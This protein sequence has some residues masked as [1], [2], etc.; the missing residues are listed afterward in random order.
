[1]KSLNQQKQFKDTTIE[2]HKRAEVVQTISKYL[3]EVLARME[4][5]LDLKRK[6]REVAKAKEELAE[7]EKKVG[8]VYKASTDFTIEKV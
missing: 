8:K 4:V 3:K 7:V 6:R 2:A 5:D 1:M